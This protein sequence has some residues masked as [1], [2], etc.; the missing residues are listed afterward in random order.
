M[1]VNDLTDLLMTENDQTTE[2]ETH[3]TKTEQLQE[4][5]Q[6]EPEIHSEL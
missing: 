5:V 4:N 3:S 6:T 2:Q 1:L